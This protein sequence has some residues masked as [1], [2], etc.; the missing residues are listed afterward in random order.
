MLNNV[1]LR[2]E[3]EIDGRVYIFWDTYF[4]ITLS[5][6][7]ALVLIPLILDGN[8]QACKQTCDWISNVTYPKNWRC[9]NL[10]PRRSCI[11]CERCGCG[12]WKCASLKEMIFLQ[13]EK[14]R[15]LQISGYVT[16]FNRIAISA[17]TV[18]R[19]KSFS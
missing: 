14:W 13:R 7:F 15:H 11:Y 19:G 5:T 8:F 6:M 16:L 9:I 4:Q 10:S 12:C 3:I 18:D 17:W 1:Q 2:F